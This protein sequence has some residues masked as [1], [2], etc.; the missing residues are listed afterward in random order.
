MYQL[1]LGSY[2]DSQAY[3]KLYENYLDAVIDADN[4]GEAEVVLVAPDWNPISE[5]NI[6][7]YELLAKY[8]S[9]TLYKY[10]MTGKLMKISF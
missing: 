9:S 10:G 5:E 8:M 6:D 2:N 4:K 3:E 7:Y 1:L